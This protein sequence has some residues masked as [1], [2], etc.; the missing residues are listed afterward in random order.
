MDPEAGARQDHTD[1]ARVLADRYWLGLIEI[2]PL[3]GTEAGDER[4]DD[5]L[6]DPSESGR[7][8]DAS[9]HRA[10]L[11]ELATIDR[12][13]LPASERGTMDVL[14]AIA[15]RGLSELE[16]RLDRLYAASYFSGPVAMPAVIASLQRADTP[17]RLDRYEAR[18]RAFP[19]YLDAWADVI[20]D[21]IA[22]GVTSPAWSWR[23]RSTSS[24]ACSPS[25]HVRAR[26]CSRSPRSAT[27]PATGSRQ[28]SV[29]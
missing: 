19:A 1:R 18:L 17:E 25:A 6:G 21:G 23:A 10:A 8:H 15:R 26:R 14:E 16:H 12:S 22:A 27:R 29:R 11:D 13:L 3:L 20:R 9:V 4:F 24:S 28:S 7:A 5:R 2:A